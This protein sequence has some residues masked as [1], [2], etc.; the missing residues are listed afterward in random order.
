MSTVDNTLTNDNFLQKLYN[1]GVR[2]LAELC[3]LSIELL[4][5]T[6]EISLLRSVSA[7]TKL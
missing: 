6:A 7:A 3:S 1:G 5:R 4:R 2:A